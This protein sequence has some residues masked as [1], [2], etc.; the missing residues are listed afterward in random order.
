MNN[1]WRNIVDAMSFQPGHKLAHYE[2][3]EPIGKGGMGE[4]YR[5]RDGKLGRDVAIKVLPDEFARD[6]ERLRRFQREAKVLASLNHPNI[7]AIYGVEQSES[8]HYLV[9]ELVPGETLA[10]RIARGPIPV[11]EAI[12]LAMKIAE[13]LESAHEQGIVHRDL[14]PANIKITPDGIVKVLDFG[15]AKAFIEDAADADSSM[16]PTLTRDATRAG[17]ILGTAAYMSPEQ[18][19]GKKLDKRA[20]VWAFGAVVYEMLTGKRAFAA[21][22]VSDTLAYV[23]AKEADWDA[24]PVD[25]SP[26]LRAFLTRCLEKDPKERVHDIADVRLAMQGAFETAAPPA[27]DS[28]PVTSRP[29]LPWVAATIVLTA[30]VVALAVWSLQ[31]PEPRPVARFVHDLPEDQRFSNRNRVLLAIAP[32]GS[33]VAYTANNQLYLRNLDETTAL[34]IPGTDEGPQNPF[35]SPDGEW[36]GYWASDQLKKIAVGGGVAVPLA[37]VD[38]PRDAVWGE[39]DTIVFGLREGVMRV[40]ANGGTPERLIAGDDTAIGWPSMLPDGETVLFVAG[41]G[42]NPQIAVQPLGSEERKVLLEGERPRYVSTGHLV[43]GRDGAL[44]AVPFDLDALEL[45]GGPVPLVEGVERGF[46]MHHYAISN[47]GTLVYV[48]A[49]ANLAEHR[50]LALAGREGETELLDLPPAEYLSPRLSP[51]GKRL[52]VQTFEEGVGVLWIYDLTA[53]SAIQ[54]FTFEGDNQRPLW[55]PEGERIT[56]ASD[57]DGTESLYWKPA[58]GSV[59][60]TFGKPTPPPPWL[61]PFDIVAKRLASALP[62]VSSSRR[63]QR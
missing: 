20:D 4:V 52:A 56:F 44:F 58:D 49:R 57:R 62:S 28:T 11:D 26:T 37:D 39:D 9:L 19:K 46:V 12:E 30:V 41:E 16:S 45:V 50:V 54:Q 5:A 18:A 1:H 47:T 17:V 55:T 36:I 61:Q 31:P 53:E 13:A 2:I 32:D 8:T 38:R 3:L 6:T 21:E 59:C 42:G 27:I 25:M 15:L 34:P 51:D 60:Q 10:E 63:V 23:L 33:R 7:A 24:L 14:K 48:A 29:V 40:S 22:D 35:F 43:Y